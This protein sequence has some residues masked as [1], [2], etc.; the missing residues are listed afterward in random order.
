MIRSMILP[1]L[2]LGALTL[3][4]PPGAAG[5]TSVQTHRQVPE[6]RSPHRRDE[7][8]DTVRTILSALGVAGLGIGFLRQRPSSRCR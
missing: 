7:S 3:A 2:L 6:R 8:P 4:A 1:I 5:G